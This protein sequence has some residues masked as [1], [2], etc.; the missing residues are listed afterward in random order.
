MKPNSHRMRRRSTLYVPGN[1]PAMLQVACVYCSDGLLFDLEDAVALK[2]KDAARILVREMLGALAFKGSEIAVRVNHLDT[3]FGLVDLETM[4]PLQP[5]ALRVPKIESAADIM[6]VIA[7]VERIENKYNLPHDR[8]KIHPMV[9]TALGVENAFAIA[10][11][12]PRVDAISIG[13][14]DLTADMQVIKSKDGTEI[15]Y[16]RRRL[17]MAA[18]AARIDCLDTVYSDVEDEEGCRAETEYIKKL[19]FTG[20]AAIH[21]RQIRIIHEVFTPTEKEVRKAERIVREFLR[22]Q[23]LGIGVFAVDGKMVDAPVV[24]RAQ[25]VLDLAGIAIDE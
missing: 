6:R 14:Q 24:A 11:A 3:P 17:V 19:G 12:H 20:K 4:V 25:Y 15:D 22:N 5:N 18:K 10:S 2:Q 1:N 13:G 8:L 7:E 21:P 9:E 23:K 16:A